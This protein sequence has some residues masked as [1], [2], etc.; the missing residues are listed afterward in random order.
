[1]NKFEIDLKHNLFRKQ[2][3]LEKFQN[4]RDMSFGAYELGKST[5]LFDTP[6]ILKVDADKC[7]IEFELIT[8][9][10]TLRKYYIN[11]SRFGT[12][13]EQ[14]SHFKYLFHSL[15][16]SLF[17]IHSGNAFFDKIQ[18]RKF[19]DGFFK[20]DF[21]TDLVY[22]HADFTMRNILYNQ[23]ND[24]LFII[25]WNIS[26]VYNFSANYGPRYWDLSFFISSFF[27]FSFTTFFSFQQKNELAKAF[28]QGYLETINIDKNIFLQNLKRFMLSYNYY[29]LYG[30]VLDSPKTISKKI[31][32]PYTKTMLN[33][34][35]QKIPELL[36]H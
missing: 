20:G 12:T 15:G 31:L 16:K 30:S 18:K 33:K 14:L 27:L 9:C 32:L 13:S 34:F 1:M 25:D 3:P 22:I 23:E 19:P 10:T 35:I 6:A 29:T 28:L 11:N 26:P 4:E 8:Q 17:F 2:I 36:I 5:E 21:K 7:E 24:K